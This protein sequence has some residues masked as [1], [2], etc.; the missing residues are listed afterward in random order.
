M[1]TANL[2]SI[3]LRLEAVAQ[4]I[5]EAEQRFGR[6][7]GAVTLVAVS[8]TRPAADVR[9]ALACGQQRFGESYLQEALPKIEQLAGLGLEWHFLGPIQSN[10]TKPIAAHFHWVHSVDRPAIA[11]RLSAQRPPELAPLNVCL[12]VNISEEPSKSG[13]SPEHVLELA[14]L[15]AELPRLKLRGL[16]A[17]PAPCDDFERQ[18]I[19]FRALC[20]LQQRLVAQGFALDTLSMGMSDDMEAA[21][22]EGATL[23]RI[24]TD[25]FGARGKTAD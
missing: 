23:V 7:P 10:K 18:R 9:A 3:R 8:K 25:I 13:V 12:Q 22:A 15:V 19:P 20:D 24:G 5:S 4:R 17:I 16:M 6:N 21:I 14:S 11:R 1:T 2:N